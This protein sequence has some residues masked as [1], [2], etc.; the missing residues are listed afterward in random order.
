M[1]ALM[2]AWKIDYVE[3][4]WGAPDQSP[5]KYGQCSTGE[6]TRRLLAEGLGETLPLQPLQ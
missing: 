4:R 1:N 6:N 2:K 5:D 3:Q